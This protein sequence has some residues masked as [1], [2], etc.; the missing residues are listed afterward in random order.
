MKRRV[1]IFIAG[2]FL[3][4]GIILASFLPKDWMDFS[5]YY[6]TAA[7]LFVIATAWFWRQKNLRAILFWAAFLFFG[8]WRFAVSLPVDSPDK[9]WHYNGQKIEFVGLIAGEPAVKG[10]RQ[11]LEIAALMGKDGQLVEGQVL[12]SADAYPRYDYGQLL[13]ISCTLKRPEKIEGFDYP[14]YLAAQGIYSTCSFPKIS[15]INTNA[16]PPKISIREKQL[17]RFGWLWG[18]IYRIREKLGEP[19]DRGLPEPEAGLLKAFLFND[20]TVP[21]DLSLSFRQSGLSHIVAISGSHISELIGMA[22]FCLLFLGINRRHA[23]WFCVPMIIFYV[24][25]IGSPASAVRAGIMGF[26]VLLAMYVGRLSRLDYTLVLSGVVMLLFNP[27]LVIADAG[28]QLSFLAV[29]GMIYLYPVFNRWLEKF[30]E[31]RPAIIKIIGET[32]ALTVAAQVFTAPILIFG[33]HQ[34]SLVAP[35]ANLFALWAAPFIMTCAFIAMALSAIIPAAAI[36]FFLPAL[37]L[38]KYLIIVAQISAS[39]PGA[40]WKF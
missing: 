5:V 26:L 34:I 35:L 17:S 9:I 30:Y 37:F 1:M 7:I 32:T 12:V 19:I 24:A 38:L 25:M 22:F 18:T 27:L 20:P 29:L 6:F 13:K 39:L 40:Y 23:F 31:G 3:A 28:F 14:K 33:F 15:V 16:L 36:Y 21:D 2:W 8:L 10:S 11:K 4:A